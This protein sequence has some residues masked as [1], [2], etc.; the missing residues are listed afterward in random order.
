MKISILLVLFAST[1]LAA[2]IQSPDK[3]TTDPVYR[4]SC[5]KCHGKTGEGRHFGGPSLRSEKVRAASTEDLRNMI[6]NGKG[7]MPK[8]GAKLSAAEIDKLVQEIQAFAKPK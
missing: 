7:R 3:L 6:T 4:K 1:I 8:F 5:A 2:Q